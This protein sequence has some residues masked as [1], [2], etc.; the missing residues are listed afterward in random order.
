M[1]RLTRKARRYTSYAELYMRARGRKNG[2][3]H[4]AGS[5]EQA[6]RIQNSLRQAVVARGL[7]ASVSGSQIFIRQGGR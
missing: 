4:D 1:R 2:L 6:R 5:P 7:V 3:V